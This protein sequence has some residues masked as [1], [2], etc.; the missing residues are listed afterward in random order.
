MFWL[1]LKGD[2]VFGSLRDDPE[3]K[4]FLQSEG[5]ASVSAYKAALSGKRGGGGGGSAKGAAATSVVYS[6]GTPGPP[7]EDHEYGR[8]TSLTK[9]ALLRLE[10]ATQARATQSTTAAKGRDYPR[11]ISPMRGGA[12]R[13]V[14][15]PE[16]GTASG[17]S[18]RT[19]PQRPDQS[20]FVD[21]ATPF[22]SWGEAYDRTQKAQSGGSA[23][24]R[25]RSTRT[26]PEQWQDIHHALDGRLDGR[27]APSTSRPASRSPSPCPATRQPVLVTAAKSPQGAAVPAPG[28]TSPQPRR[29]N[30]SERGSIPK[31]IPVG[32]GGQA[33]AAVLDEWRDLK[34]QQITSPCPEFHVG[35]APWKSGGGHSFGTS[36]R[37]SAR[38][39][40]RGRPGDPPILQRT[41][42]AAGRSSSRTRSASPQV[43]GSTERGAKGGGSFTAPL[44]R[45]PARSASRGASPSPQ[46]R[47]GR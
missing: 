10:A 24:S 8:Y 47:I 33:A 43:A 11:S 12:A 22:Y 29:G 2:P 28:R 21:A 42:L 7:W 13:R 46:R 36:V 34:Q 19:E 26:Q 15:T 41:P 3:I 23:W 32:A 9:T 17:W 5:T 27:S 31:P 14:L 1:S 25:E 35:H 30:A 39:D 20:V 4:A 45:S 40:E 18:R 16:P 37:P 38:T 44:Y 6:A